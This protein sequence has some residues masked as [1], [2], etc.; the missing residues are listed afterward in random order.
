MASSRSSTYELDRCDSTTW[1]IPHDGDIDQWRWLPERSFAFPALGCRDFAKL[2]RTWR[3][4]HMD[5]RIGLLGGFRA[6]AVHLGEASASCK[7]CRAPLF[8]GETRTKCCTFYDA[9]RGD[10]A[11][12]CGPFCSFPC[13]PRPTAEAEN[14][15][16]SCEYGALWYGH[17]ELSKYFRANTRLFNSRYAFSSLEATRKRHPGKPKFQLK[18]T[19]YYRIAPSMIHPPHWKTGAAQRIDYAQL[20]TLDPDE[21]FDERLERLLSTKLEDA[22]SDDDDGGA[23]Q[24]NRREP[25]A[26]QRLKTVMRTVNSTM[27]ANPLALQY[28]AAFDA[29]GAAPTA[30]V[31]IHTDPSELPKG[32]A[33]AG[34]HERQYNAPTAGNVSVVLHA[35]SPDVGF[36]VLVQRQVAGGLQRVSYSN[37]SYDSLAFPLY[38]P[39]G[40]ATWHHGFKAPVVA[41]WRAKPSWH[42]VEM[43]QFYAERQYNAPTAGN[44]SVVLHAPSPDVGFDVL[45]QR[46]V[47]GGLQRVSYSNSSYDSLAFPLYFPRGTA[48]WHHGFKAPVVAQ[49]RAKPSWHK[50]EMQQ[51]YASMLYV[52]RDWIEMPVD[53]AQPN[54]ERDNLQKASWRVKVPAGTA[55]AKRDAADNK[56]YVANDNLWFFRGGRLFQQFLC[57]AA[58]RVELKRLSTLATPTLQKQ[59]RAES[60]QTLVDAIDD[61]ATPGAIGRKVICPASVKGSRRAMYKL[62][63][64]CMAIVRKFGSPNLFITVCSEGSSRRCEANLDEPVWQDP[65]ASEAC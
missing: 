22:D 35:P 4:V 2:E 3:L 56:W 25:V 6:A 29:S 57:T 31:R 7:G 30:H 12:W 5:L 64:D 19:V 14:K 50:V 52:R 59:L 44:V 37:S 10:R 65:H 33:A 53:V 1:L 27:H 32:G 47:A 55:R 23:V 34:A 11:G 40:T 62:F 54:A 17:D 24:R 39:R 63:L 28:K 46:Q 43:Q 8:L 20:Y 38:F 51:F 49:W 58:A 18:G 16:I 48:T 41:Q 45:V 61:G 9:R 13:I 42:K 60:Y 15:E 26:V 36:D 21:G